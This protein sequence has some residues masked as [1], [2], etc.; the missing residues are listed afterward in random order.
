V[1]TDSSVRT[2]AFLGDY[3]PRKCGIATFTADLLEAV[4][5]RHSQSQCFA[6]RSTTSMGAIAIPTSFASRLRN[7]IQIPTGALLPAHPMRQVDITRRLHQDL[8]PGQNRP[9]LQW[10]KQYGRNTILGGENHETC[11][12]FIRTTDSADKGANHAKPWK[13]NGLGHDGPSTA[14]GNKVKR[15]SRRDV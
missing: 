6:C 2:V 4:A 8:R 14:D 13:G 12:H 15:H 7:R 3:L 10:N 11:R 9:W 5:A 1:R